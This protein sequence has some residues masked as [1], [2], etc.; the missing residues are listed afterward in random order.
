MTPARWWHLSTFAV[1]GASLL[2]QLVLVV[3]SDNDTL[4]VRLIR[5]ISYFTIQSN[6]IV[7]VVSFTLLRDPARDGDFW[8][9]AR[10]VSVVC[11]AVTGLVYVSVLRGLFEL[12]PA[13]RVADTGLHYLTPLLAVFGWLLF[14]PRPRVERRTVALALVFPVAWLVYTL[15][16]GALIDEYPYPFVDVATKGYPTVLTNCAVVTVVFLAVAALV[17]LA[18]RSLPKA[19]GPERVGRRAGLP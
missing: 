8:R 10:L 1:S 19:P 18:D 3:V 11:I 9:I 2:L 6:L 17:F 12:T 5:L 14:G 4:G 15:I 16:R 7:C 13:A